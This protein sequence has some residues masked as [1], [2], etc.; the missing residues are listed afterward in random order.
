MPFTDRLRNFIR[1]KVLERDLDDE[2]A[3]HID[4][5]REEYIAQG[6]DPAEAQLLARK[7]FGRVTQIREETRSMNLVLWLE[8]LTQDLRF[9]ARQLRR[10]RTLAL[11][12]ILTLALGMGATTAVFTLTD[13]ALFK[14]LPY[15]NADRLVALHDQF[16]NSMASPTIPEFLDYQASNQSFEQMAFFD[17]RDYQITGSDEP[18]RVSAARVTATYFPLLGAKPPLGRVFTEAEIAN[19]TSDAVVLS[20]NFWRRAFGA[21]PGV[22]GRRLDVNGLTGT[23]IGVLQEG[24]SLDY[25]TLS[26]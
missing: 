16:P 22:I 13:T 1:G 18:E 5:R 25:A 14:P 20:H 9:G 2:L 7:D 24:F 17:S 6:L 8:T 15:P 11:T 12:S 4:A 19:G 21:D 23:V 26:F 3:F 10:N